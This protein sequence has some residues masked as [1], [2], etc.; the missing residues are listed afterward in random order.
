MPVYFEIVL[1]IKE[2]PPGSKIY[3]RDAVRG[4][5]INDR[6]EIFMIHTSK[7]DYKFPG[8]GIE[9][10]ENH[11]DAL[12]REFAE[13]T[14]YEITGNTEL[15]G[16]VIEQRPD[17]YEPGAFFVMTSYYYRCEII[18]EYKGQKL[19][20]YEKEL[21]FRGEYVPVLTAY[22]QNLHLINSGTDINPWVKREKIV[23]ENII[24]IF[25]ING[26]IEKVN[27]GLQK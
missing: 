18:G 21:D 3:R 12:N 10:G 26:S 15:I 11:F 1:G 2:I 6:N 7:G 17:A 23:L 4:F 13:E 5:V 20:E 27:S 24:R 8:G 14:G 22:R 19:D 9:D 25:G 16:M